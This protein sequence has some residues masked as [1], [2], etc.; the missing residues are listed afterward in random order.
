[1][2]LTNTQEEYLKRVRGNSGVSATAQKMVLQYR[3]NII[4]IDRKIIKELN[5]L[6]MGLY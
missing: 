1:M 2:K 3:E 5:R 4:A 6:F